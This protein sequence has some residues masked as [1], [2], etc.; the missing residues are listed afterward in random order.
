MNAATVMMQE[1]DSHLLFVTVAGC[2]A[3]FAI[4]RHGRR[5][6]VLVLLGGVLLGLTI[7]GMLVAAM[8][9]VTIIP[10]PTESAAGPAVGASGS[11]A[12]AVAAVSVCLL[13]LSMV[14]SLVYQHRSATARKEV[15]RLHQFAAASREGM[16][17]H[18]DGIILDVNQTLARMLGQESSQWIGRNV[19]EIVAPDFVGVAEARLRQPDLLRTPLQHAIEIELNGAAGRPLPVQVISRPIQFDGRPAVIAT[20]RDLSMRKDA[21]AY[22]THLAQHDTLMNLVDRLVFDARLAES[23][24]DAG[25]ADGVIG[26]FC[27][28]VD[29][30]SSINARLGQFAG[31]RAL[32]ELAAR[33][34]RQVRPLDTVARLSGDDFAVIQPFAAAPR[35]VTDLA[36]RII[37][38]LAPPLQ[39][40][41]QMVELGVSVGIAA[42][43]TD[44]T[45]PE[46]LLLAADAALTRAKSEGRSRY[47]LY[48][49]SVDLVHQQRRSLEH[50]LRHAI[51][52]HQLELYYQPIFDIATGRL[53]GC[54]ALLRW[55]HPSRGFVSPADFIPF[56]EDTGLI[57]P[58]GA[59]VLETAC[60]EAASWLRPWSVAVNLSPVQFRL[61][62]LPL[63]V[64]NVLARVGLTPTR[65]VLEVTE[66]V[67]VENADQAACTLRALQAQGISLSLDDFGTGYS[68]LSYLSRFPFKKLKIDRS[69]VQPLAERPDALAVVRAII[70][71]GHS[72]GLDIIA[73]GVETQEQLDLLHAQQCEFA[74]GFLLGR[75]MPRDALRELMAERAAETDPSAAHAAALE[76]PE[77]LRPS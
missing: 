27:I 3:A 7:S 12:I 54:E 16:V 68:S 67:L 50:D 34:R 6:G 14:G 41:G 71:L 15:Q 56:A 11:L 26:L 74:Q 46:A 47:C 29:G 25:K 64:A 61:P 60:V 35:Q 36:E 53:A 37:D 63:L 52:R 39:L 19:L 40:R 8:V 58:I 73:E 17:I 24:E 72:L 32:L 13:I 20:L 9:G 62:N 51:E 38:A 18:R 42:F 77:P 28:N 75:P 66:G 69:F 22:A 70:A 49:R 2:V 65:L 44:G 5:H 10:G 48:D 30:F 59:W 31:D 33:L 4:A 21:E 1:H 23:I 57:N 55:R 45:T 76:I 43:P